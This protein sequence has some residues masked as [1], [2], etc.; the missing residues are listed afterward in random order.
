MHFKKWIRIYFC[1]IYVTVKHTEKYKLSSFKKRD[2]AFRE[3]DIQ[4]TQM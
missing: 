3:D 4:I 2:H 1:Q